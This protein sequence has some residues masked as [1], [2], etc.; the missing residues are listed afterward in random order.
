MIPI[1]A[2]SL[3]LIAF[4]SQDFD[5]K[6]V[7]EWVNQ[8]K[9]DDIAVR[10][11]ATKKLVE[12]G[13]KVL[14]PLEKHAK[15]EDGDFR[16]RVAYIIKRLTLKPWKADEALQAAKA[17]LKEDSKPDA[18][19]TELRKQFQR[20]LDE[21][22]TDGSADS[23]K[24]VGKYFEEAFAERRPVSRQLGAKP[25]EG[26]FLVAAAKGSKIKEALLVC[27]SVEATEIE[28]SVI[29]CAGNVKATKLRKC[30]VFATGKIEAE[31]IED[32]VVYCGSALICARKS[33][34]C[35]ILAAGAQ[36]FAET[37]EVTFINSPK[38]KVANPRGERDVEKSMLPKQKE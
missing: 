29:A 1:L 38:R 18:W 12:C 19:R 4:L 21:I 34:K 23:L 15:S 31:E 7:E 30:F 9:S 6:K 32:C 36:E 3:L 16:S 24:F 28:R 37:N 8:L 33:R 14:P 17:A 13:E 35:T 11:A 20:V 26:T 5:P 22:G 10:E 27:E 25:E 2:R